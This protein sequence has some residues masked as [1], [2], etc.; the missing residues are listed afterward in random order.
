MKKTTAYREKNRLAEEP[1]AEPLVTLMIDTRF[2]LKPFAQPG[3]GVGRLHPIAICWNWR[4]V[5]S[6]HKDTQ[7]VATGSVR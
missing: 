4:T 6:G 7:S 5:H 2:L 3:R 1:P